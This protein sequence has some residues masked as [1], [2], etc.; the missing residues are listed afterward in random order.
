VGGVRG[1]PD[2]WAPEQAKDARSADVRAD[3]YSLGCVLFHCLT[4]RPPFPDTSLMAQMLRHATETPAPLA[5]LAADVPPGLQA[6]VDRL[7]AKSPD[8]R[9]ATP[10]EA[11]RALVPFL[12]PGGSPPKPAAVVPE[13][14][15]WLETESQLELPKDLPPESVKPAPVK[16][17][18]QPA[19][20]LKTGGTA[21]APALPA[22]PAPVKPANA[23]TV[24]AKPARPA[25]P[26]PGDEDEVNVELVPE[27]LPLPA[28]PP[29]L[30]EVREERGLL[31][32]DRRDWI[33]LAAG[34]ASV[35]GAVGLGYG[36]ARLVRKKPEEAPPDEG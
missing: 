18:T 23:A 28:A 15:A 2:Y 3:V 4:G 26:L 14:K 32:F 1:T 30:P 16:P 8:E 13:F 21:P 10:G 27:P 22:R 9:Y 5:S 35:L 19:A 31:E 33:M 36:L 11:A 6:V 24:A 29:P 25:V 17:G 20:P 34:A 7:L 12:G